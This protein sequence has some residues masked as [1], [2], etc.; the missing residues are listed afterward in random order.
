MRSCMNVCIDESYVHAFIS[1]GVRILRY[2]VMWFSIFRYPVT[3]FRILQYP[4]TQ[5]SISNRPP[6]SRTVPHACKVVSRTLHALSLCEI[7]HT[8]L[9]GLCECLW[10]YVHDCI[11][12]L[13][14]LVHLWWWWWNENDENISWW[15]HLM[16]I[17]LV[18]MMN[19]ELYVLD[20]VISLMMMILISCLYSWDDD[21]IYFDIIW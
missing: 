10:R 5:G 8:W 3:R 20:L 7:S 4:V 2:L 12:P 14:I 19:R 13:V 1:H 18:M 21:C 9:C 6:T 11:R 16:M 15:F 17:I